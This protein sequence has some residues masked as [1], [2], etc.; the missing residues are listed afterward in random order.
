M[1]EHAQETPAGVSVTLRTAVAIFMA[2]RAQ[3]RERMRDVSAL[4]RRISS[5]EGAANHIYSKAII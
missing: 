2:G 1:Q 3:V 5:M 4:Q